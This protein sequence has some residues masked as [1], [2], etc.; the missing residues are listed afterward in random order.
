MPLGY[1]YQNE[2][3]FDVALAYLEDELG[4]DTDAWLNRFYD[5]VDRMEPGFA[6]PWNWG[7]DY[8]IELIGEGNLSPEEAAEDY[9]NEYASVYLPAHGEKLRHRGETTMKVLKDVYGDDL[10]SVLRQSRGRRRLMSGYGGWDPPEDPLEDLWNE[11]LSEF[12]NEFEWLYDHVDVERYFNR[13]SG[14]ED[15]HPY[16]P[17]F[18][19]V[20]EDF[21]CADGYW[22]DIAVEYMEDV[23]KAAETLYG[24]PVADGVEGLL[25]A[26]GEWGW[27]GD[28]W[29]D[30]VFEKCFCECLE[31][32]E[33]ARKLVEAA[34]LA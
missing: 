28:E 4:I 13:Y 2:T 15:G 20:A 5:A 16:G 19:Y 26:D 33:A 22:D 12:I 8:I 25:Y 27:E 9:L 7:W 29:P 3:D 14:V 18:D 11:F 30:F 34:G 31:P 6:F 21:L 23:V 32:N 24:K 17:T 1:D 10:P